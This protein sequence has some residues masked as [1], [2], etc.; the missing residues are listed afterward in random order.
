MHTPHIWN[1]NR[2]TGNQGAFAL[3]TLPTHIINY[4][5]LVTTISIHYSDAIVSAMAAQKIY[6]SHLPDPTGFPWMFLVVSHLTNKLPSIIFFFFRVQVP[7]D[8]RTADN[9]Y[10]VSLVCSG[11]QGGNPSSSVDPIVTTRI[12]RKS[13][14]NTLTGLKRVRFNRQGLINTCRYMTNCRRILIYL[15]FSNRYVFLFIISVTHNYDL[16][17]LFHHQWFRK[18]ALSLSMY[19]W[20]YLNKPT[21]HNGSFML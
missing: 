13:K 14:Y 6:S 4:G 10:E 18:L 12:M 20:L 11:T 15:N 7:R 1:S 19:K 9:R 3:M 17:R 21:W 8:S 16:W 5:K 2:V